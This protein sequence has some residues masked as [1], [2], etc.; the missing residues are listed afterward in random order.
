MLALE[1]IALHWKC[2]HHRQLGRMIKSDPARMM[3]NRPPGYKIT[4][5]G[6][7]VA[8]ETGPHGA[9]RSYS[10]E[11]DVRDESGNILIAILQ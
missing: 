4:R 8:H 1:K 5:S 7:L 11:D 3:P 9:H 10:I 2:G 6:Y